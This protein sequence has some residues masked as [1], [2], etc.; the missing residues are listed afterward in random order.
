MAV[1]AR[2][3]ARSDPLDALADFVARHPR[4]LC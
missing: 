1:A 4:L 2:S 3:P